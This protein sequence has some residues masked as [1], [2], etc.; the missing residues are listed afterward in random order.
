MNW[1]AVAAVSE[2][3]GAVGVIVTVVYLALQIRQNTKSIQGSTEQAL[4]NAEVTVFGLF[5]EHA[6][7]VR[8]AADSVVEL[9]PDEEA[10]YEYLV[11]AEMSQLYGAFVQYQRKLIPESVWNA[12]LSS[13]T[14]NHKKPGFQ[15][16]W[17]RIQTSWPI[18]F[19][20]CL[21]TGLD[22]PAG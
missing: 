12:Y 21:E 15:R 4:M 13:W 18:E 22:N 5:A 17:S 19:A 1:D 3:L 2:A 10:L 8:R 14:E 16:V 9:D 11:G 7:V 6:S 20:E